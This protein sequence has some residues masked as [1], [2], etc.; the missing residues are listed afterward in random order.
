MQKVAL[1]RA[2]SFHPRLLLLDE[3][4][5]NIDPATT[6]EIENMLQKITK[7]DKTKI[8]L[9]THNLAQVKRLCKQVVVMHNGRII[10]QGSC[11]IMLTNPNTKT[12]RKFIG[13]ELLVD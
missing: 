7:E 12:A 2:V 11:K 8:L 6:S 10:E 5:V 3:P 9:V 1:A 4:T 13:G